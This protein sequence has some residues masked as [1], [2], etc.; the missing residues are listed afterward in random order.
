[1]A[2][3]VIDW[4]ATISALTAC[5]AL[6]SAL[7]AL[8]SARKAHRVAQVSVAATVELELIKFREAWIQRLREEMSTVAGYAAFDPDLSKEENIQFFKSHVKMLLLMNPRDDEYEAFNELT[9]QLY[10]HL[11]NP[12]EEVIDFDKRKWTSKCQH[13]LKVEWDRLNDEVAKYKN[14]AGNKNAKNK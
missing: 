4:S 3:Y 13:I 5:V 12:D 10:R 7:I 1:M 14:L 11:N 6:I 9:E 2:E 8:Y